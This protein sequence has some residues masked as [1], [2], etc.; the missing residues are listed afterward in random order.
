MRTQTHW[1]VSFFGSRSSKRNLKGGAI[2]LESLYR[3]FVH[4]LLLLLLWSLLWSLSL[5]LLFAVVA[6]AVVV[7]VCK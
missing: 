1:D 2:D 4:Y 5:L 6:A 7:A 3:L